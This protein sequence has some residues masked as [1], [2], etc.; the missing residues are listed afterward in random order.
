MIRYAV[1]VLAMTALA[2]T[3]AHA[4]EVQIQAQGPVVELTVNEI[5]HSAPDV[6][7]IGAGVTTRA[8]TAQ[9][10]VRQN[11]QAMEQVI[12][13][14]RELGIASR[15]IQTSNFNL[16]PQYDYDRNGGARTFV[17]YDVNNQVQVKLRDL[18]RAGEVLDAL[19]SAG[20]NNIYGPNFMLEADEAAKREART[21]AYQSGQA[22]AQE[23]ARMAGYSGVRLLEISETFQ[24]YG[25]QPVMMRAS[26]EAAADAGTQ[27]EPGEVGT[28]VTVTVKYE[29]TR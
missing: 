16:N 13:K 24:S 4:A 3:A 9:E 23:Y 19:V 6:A 11:A 8:P 12:A 25:P 22:M 29:M 18:E 2:A 26:A 10:A 15:D 1:P 27:I 17:G 14:L 20:A 5:V 7:Q 21:K 28:G